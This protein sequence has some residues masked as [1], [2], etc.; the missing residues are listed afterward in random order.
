MEY[1][2]VVEDSAEAYPDAP[3]EHREVS[4]W[5]PVT[6][7][8]WRAVE[9]A[10]DSDT[11]GTGTGDGVLQ[12][13]SR[14]RSLQFRHVQGPIVSGAV[15]IA[16]VELAERVIVSVEGEPPSIPSRY[17]LYPNY[18][19]PFNPS[20]RFVLDLPARGHVT[21]TIY[22]LLGRP[23]T[24]LLDAV[25]DAGTHAVDW[26]VGNGKTPSSGMYIVRCTVRGVVGGVVFV[27]SAR[28]MLLK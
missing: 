27:S 25:R 28:V 16:G 14:L 26:N 19:N 10:F 21:L 24:T 18:P 1:R 17:T 15:Y 4:R 22:D 13:E 20:T 11:A 2:F 8:G 23:V 9:W 12:G 5:Q 7:V 3:P 6:W